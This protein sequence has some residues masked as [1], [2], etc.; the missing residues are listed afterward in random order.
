MG[1]DYLQVRESGL[2]RI[3]LPRTWVNKGRKWAGAATLRP[4]RCWPLPRFTSFPREDARG[5]TMSARNL[6]TS[7]R[8]RRGAPRATRTGRSVRRRRAHTHAPGSQAAK[9][10]GFRLRRSGAGPLGSVTEPT[11]I[12]YVVLLTTVSLSETALWGWDVWVLRVG[13][14]SWS[15]RSRVRTWS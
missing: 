3:Y 11:P 14:A 9:S 6:R 2:R 12:T 13:C 4:S 10:A 8:S 5:S 7:S 1:E 15:G